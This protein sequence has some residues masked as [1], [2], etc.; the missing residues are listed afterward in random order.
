[1]WLV[2]KVDNLTAICELSKKG[3][4]QPITGIASQFH[5]YFIMC[6][7]IWRTTDMLAVSIS[8]NIVS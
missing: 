5:F 8:I 4:S 1:V 2:H 3:A 6:V 7:G